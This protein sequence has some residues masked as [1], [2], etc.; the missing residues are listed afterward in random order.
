MVI[1]LHHIIEACFYRP[2]MLVLHSFPN[3]NSQQVI[4]AKVNISTHL[5]TYILYRG[6]SALILT[7]M[8]SSSL[9]NSVLWAGFQN[10]FSPQKNFNYWLA[11]SK[12]VKCLQCFTRKLIKCTSNPCEGNTDTDHLKLDLKVRFHEKSSLL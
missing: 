2:A 6:F 12:A 3:C 9:S 8:T 7:S 1:N 11:I 4:T 5:P 10:N